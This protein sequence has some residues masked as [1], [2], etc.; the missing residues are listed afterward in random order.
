[1]SS[2]ETWRGV[3]AEDAED[4]PQAWAGLLAKAHPPPPR[5]PSARL[6]AAPSSCS[7]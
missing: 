2:I 1:M 3:A 7:R 4:V 6:T 5:R